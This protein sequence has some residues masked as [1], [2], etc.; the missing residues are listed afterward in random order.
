MAS[1]SPKRLDQHGPEGKALQTAVKT[2][3][4]D[5]LGEDYNDDVRKAPA[6]RAVHG[7]AAAQSRVMYFTFDRPC[8]PQVLPLYVV[9]MMA[10][11]TTQPVVAENLD[12]FLGENA[13]AFTSWCGV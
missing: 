10:H 6:L 1:T 13:V 12:A 9:V 2:K 7:G 4:K 5:F 11:G 8:P 3:L